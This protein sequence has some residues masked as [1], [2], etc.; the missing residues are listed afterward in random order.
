MQKDYIILSGK[1]YRVEVNWN[2]IL[3]FAE[4]RG[5]KNIGELMDVNEID[6]DN[7]ADLCAAGIREGERLEGRECRITGKEV[8]ELIAPREMMR[9]V[10]I[11]VSHISPKL[12]EEEGDGEEKERP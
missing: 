7:V 11:Y 10:G 5:L 6:K 3:D 9:F 4:Q 1:R 12:P 8:A 2:A